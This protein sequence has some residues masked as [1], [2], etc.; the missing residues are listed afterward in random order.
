VDTP[1]ISIITVVYNGEEYLEKTIQSVVTQSYKNI[2]FIVVDGGSK[3]N[4]L[5]IIKKYEDKISRWITESDKGIY[6]AMNKGLSLASGEWVNFLNGGDIFYDDG[7]ITN[8]VKALNSQ[9]LLVYGDSINVAPHFQKYIKP[10]PDLSKRTIRRSLGLCH[11]A[12]F[13]NRKVVPKYDLSYRYK[14]EYNWVID[15]VS[16][17]E[18]ASIQYIPVPI[19]Y[20]SLGGFSERGMLKNLKEFIRVTYRRF[21]VTQVILNTFMYLKIFLRFIKYKFVRS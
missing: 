21:G 9:A 11:Q 4:T 1:K 15:I 8:F 17:I 6:D 7:V 10:V 14:A 13:A 18:P 2:E 19:V 3:D 5:T 12:V 16:S 20:Y